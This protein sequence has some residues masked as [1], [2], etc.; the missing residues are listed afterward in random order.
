VER[1]YLIELEVVVDVVADKMGTALT[2]QIPGGIAQELQ[3]KEE[4]CGGNILAVPLALPL[5]VL[6]VTNRNK[7]DMTQTLAKLVLLFATAMP[8]CKGDLVPIPATWGQLIESQ[9]FDY[10]ELQ[11][12]PL[13][14]VS[15]FFCENKKNV[16]RSFELLTFSR[17]K[18]RF[19]PHYLAAFHRHLEFFTCKI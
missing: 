6:W 11:T 1:F 18:N 7:G 2:F 5:S 15:A 10:S 16:Q 8:R 13:C 14:R 9:Q 12:E 4:N 19:H 3:G 17:T